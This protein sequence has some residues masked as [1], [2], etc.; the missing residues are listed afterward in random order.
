MSSDSLKSNSPFDGEPSSEEAL[1][2]A[3]GSVRALAAGRFTVLGPLG[4]DLEGTFAFLA[5]DLSANLLV[6][7]KARRASLDTDAPLVLKVKIGRAS[8]RERVLLR[9]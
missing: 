8:C 4:R 5:R 1:A 6:V 7:L 2:N 9:V 3:L